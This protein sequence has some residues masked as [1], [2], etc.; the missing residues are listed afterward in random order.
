MKKT[1]H[2]NR[3]ACVFALA[4]AGAWLLTLFAAGCGGKQEAPP[5]QSDQ[6]AS[7][8]A[9]EGGD[10]KAAETPEPAKAE[11]SGAAAEPKGG[12][13]PPPRS[14]SHGSSA[15]SSAGQNGQTAHGGTA[16]GAAGAEKPKP[17]E[18]KYTMVGLH[19]GKKIKTALSTPLSSKTSKVG[20]PFEATVIKDVRPRN[21]ETVAIPEGS[22]VIGEVIEV[23]EAKAL[24][25][26]AKLGI[27]VVKVVLPSGKE[28]EIVASLA[29]DGKD[30]TK[31]TVGG[32][33]GG[34]AAGAILGRII[35]KDSKGAA[36]GA[37]AGAAIGTGVVL[38]MDNKD[39]EL[40]AGTELHFH[41]DQEHEVPV[42]QTQS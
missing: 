42:P 26:Q 19:E 39:V 11:T 4:L 8:T 10:A 7:N 29:A 3:G 35:G 13:T 2:G 15:G 41:L 9:G 18:P 5:P 30:T 6:T 34:A 25:G 40:P 17:A 32:I 23:R 28:I 36:I 14:S 20:D 12:S 1:S 33:A 22:V 31:R 24:K 37:V 21:S 27:K 16:S 38:G